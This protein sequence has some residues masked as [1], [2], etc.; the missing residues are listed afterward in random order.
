M[1]LF[2]LCCHF[3]SEVGLHWDLLILV[4]RQINVYRK[5][6]DQRTGYSPNP[7][8]FLLSSFLKGHFRYLEVFESAQK[9]PN[10][11]CTMIKTGVFTLIRL[12]CHDA[13]KPYTVSLSRLLRDFQFWLFI[14]VRCREVY[15]VVF[16][17]SFVVMG[18]WGLE[19]LTETF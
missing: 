4:S 19:N 14:F 3:N 5:Y 13:A 12:N 9:R 18:R 1:F 8:L 10:I 17:H 6:S 7:K 16:S 15:H 11:F 2:S